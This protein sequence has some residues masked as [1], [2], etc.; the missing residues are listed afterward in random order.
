[1]MDELYLRAGLENLRFAVPVSSIV[2]IISDPTAAEIPDAPE[3]ICGI[4]YHE[5]EIF[6]I[7]SLKPDRMTPPRLLILYKDG[8]GCAAY[9]ADWVAAMEEM[10]E[11]ELKDVLPAGETGILLLNKKERN[12]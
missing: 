2:K 3:G 12:G 7:R 4:L 6:V 8:K 11:E 5:Q 9:A 10:T 1:M